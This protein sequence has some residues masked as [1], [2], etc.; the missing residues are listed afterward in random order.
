MPRSLVIRVPCRLGAKRTRPTYNA[1]NQKRTPVS[2]N[3]RQRQGNAQ[4]EDLTPG[5]RRPVDA[6]GLRVELRAVRDRAGGAPGGG[7]AGHCRRSQDPKGRTG[8]LPRS[9]RPRPQRRLA[10]RLHRRRPQPPAGAAAGRAALYRPG[11]PGR[12]GRRAARL[13]GP[14]RPARQRVGEQAGGPGSSQAADDAVPLRRGHRIRRCAAA[15]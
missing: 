1:R 3:G 11:L 8:T 2:R 5:C 9:G 7:D 6:L 10:R 15:H 12:R 14:G 4:A 13:L